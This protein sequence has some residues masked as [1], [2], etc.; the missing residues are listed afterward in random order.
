M[1]SMVESAKA[2]RW[3][4]RRRP[5][6]VAFVASLGHERFSPN[7]LLAQAVEAERAG[8]DGICCS[9]HIAPWWPPGDPSPAHCG[10]AWVW[11]GAAGAATSEISLGTGVTGLVHRYNP[12]VVAQQLATLESLY[13]GRAFLGVGSS[14]AMNEVPAGFDWPAPREQLA[15]TEEALTIIV[16]LLNGETVDFEGRYFRTHGAR[17]YLETDRRPPVYMSAFGEQAAQMAGRLADGVLTLADPQKAPQVIAGYR[18]G[19][20]EAGREPGEIVLQGLVAWAEDDDAALDGAREWKAT[21]VDAHY[22]DPVA[23]PAQ[24]ESNGRDVP[25]AQFK[26]MAAVSSNPKAHLRRIKAM[27]ELGAT[28]IVLMNVSGADPIG[29]LRMYGESVL[30]ELRD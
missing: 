17:I 7:E 25:D 2:I 28:A 3:A 22:T 18:R 19:C 29:T 26:A 21:L 13:P 1:P 12:V 23:D 27:R 4:R 9:D 15:R 16:R 11:L 14:E 10:N 5:D 8:F 24:I 30:P 6:E 20:E